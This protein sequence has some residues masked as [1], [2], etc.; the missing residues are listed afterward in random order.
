MKKIILLAMILMS[1]SL[2][3]A[4]VTTL[5]VSWQLSSSTLNPSSIATISLAVSNPGADISNVFIN[6]TTGPYLTITSG[7][8][9]ELGG[10]A[11]GESSQAAI[12]IK[13]DDNAPSTTSY[14]SLVVDYYT[15]TSNYEKTFNI[16]I[17][18]TRKPILQIENVSFSTALEP[19]VTSTLSFDL[20]NDG[21]GAAKD[22]KVL[23]PQM[24]DFITSSSSG[25]FFISNLDSSD[26]STI[27]V[28]LTVSPDASIGT[29]S[30]PVQISY[31]DEI[32]SNNYTDT[33]EIGAV[34]SGSYNFIV[35]LD[36]QDV[37]TTGTSGSVTVKIANAGNQQAKFVTLKVVPSNNFVL[38][39]TTVYIGDLNSDDYDTEKLSLGV[40]SVSPG[41]YPLSFQIGY[42]DS[43][44]KNYN[45]IYSVNVKV[46]SAS[47]YRA[48]S[49]SQ[50]P[51]GLLI[52]VIVVI[53]VFVISYRK[54]Y[55]NRLFGRK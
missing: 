11:S 18:I 42:Q 27:T 46:S 4:A 3:E 40:G 49:Q 47:E 17:T 36:S 55:L 33:K 24:S 32:R 14:V 30:I 44:G 20:K 43:F 5:N 50:S 28:P 8:K 19:G 35:N 21:L 10:I 2:A 29:T 16:P 23:F 25:E 53:V 54:G 48:A 26:S 15:S 12:S 7:G 34:I 9:I 52:V 39:P 38:S 45:E 51:I 22:I 41:S 31:Y 1:V 37:V 13:V 6:S